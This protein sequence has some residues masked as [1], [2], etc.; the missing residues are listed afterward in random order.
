VK[1]DLRD[2]STGVRITLTLPGEHAALVLIGRKEKA[3]IGSYEPS[4]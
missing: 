4:R 3:M 2:K 1:L